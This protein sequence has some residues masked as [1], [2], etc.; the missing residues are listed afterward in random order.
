[1]LSTQHLRHLE[2]DFAPFYNKTYV[3]QLTSM[4]RGT[5]GLSC[6]LFFC[7]NAMARTNSEWFCKYIDLAEQERSK[8]EQDYGTLQPDDCASSHLIARNESA[9]RLQPLQCASKVIQIRSW[10]RKRSCLVRLQSY[11][12]TQCCLQQE[13]NSTKP[14]L[15]QTD[16]HCWWN[17]CLGSS[18][19][20]SHSYR[21]IQ[22]QDIMNYNQSPVQKPW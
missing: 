2:V 16:P 7:V 3:H 14:Q 20:C 4:C 11:W 19:V 17:C 12:R 8:H 6:R 18:H 10:L 21:C 5:T 22:L 13:K 9:V 15:Q 1:M